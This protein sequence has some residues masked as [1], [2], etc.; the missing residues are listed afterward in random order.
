MISPDYS[1]VIPAYNEAELLPN[2][3]ISLQ[4][5]MEEI[6]MET[7]LSGEIIV[8]DNNSDDG[9][10][11]LAEKMGATT[12][13]EPVKCIARSRNKG[14]E[15]ARGQYLIFIDADTIPPTRLISEALKELSSG[16]ICGGGS[17]IGFLEK[18]IPLTANICA[19]IWHFLIAVWPCAAGS[20]V[21]C[22]K[23]AWKSVGGF[24]ETFYAAE[25]IAFSKSLK[26]YGAAR[27]QRFKNIPIP[28]LTSAR[29]F[30][31]YGSFGLIRK[32]LLIAV[33]PNSL[34]SRKHCS[35]WYER[36]KN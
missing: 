22:L 35:L 28:V 25:E 21:F 5:S 8:V 1:I 29:K 16:K 13:F 36:P 26:K 4:K 20:F 32:M 3:L 18:D 2:T 9:T 33:Y 14:A 24:D 27:S 10:A 23:D 34:K 6:R 12:V 17:K 31:W 7:N 19:L 15:S 11:T 30:K